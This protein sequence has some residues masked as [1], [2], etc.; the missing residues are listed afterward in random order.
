M[1]IDSAASQA[2]ANFAK[3][4]RNTSCDGTQI[5]IFSN[6]ATEEVLVVSRLVIKSDTN[7]FCCMP[8][9][10]DLCGDNGERM[11]S[12]PC[13]IPC[14]LGDT[15]GSMDCGSLVP[16]PEVEPVYRSL[17]G[18]PPVAAV[19][20]LDIP[21]P[22]G[23]VVANGD[24]SKHFLL[25]IGHL[26]LSE[27]GVSDA[28]AAGRFENAAVYRH[29]VGRACI[30]A[31]LLAMREN[32]VEP[33]LVFDMD[34][35]DVSGEAICC[36]MDGLFD[37]LVPG[38]HVVICVPPFDAEGRPQ[39]DCAFDVVLKYPPHTDEV[40][41]L[42]LVHNI[43]P[44]DPKGFQMQD[45]D[46]FI[47]SNVDLSL[48]ISGE[49]SPGVCSQVKLL[50][51]SAYLP[52][53]DKAA[54]EA[55]AAELDRL[56]DGMLYRSLT[57]ADS[58]LDYH[59]WGEAC[60]KFQELRRVGYWGKLG[61]YLAAHG[62]PDM[63]GCPLHC[64]NITG[65]LL[66]EHS[67]AAKL[68]I[69]RGTETADSVRARM[70]AAERKRTSAAADLPAAAAQPPPRPASLGTAA[71]LKAMLSVAHPR[72]RDLVSVYTAGVD[73]GLVENIFGIDCILFERMT[74]PQLEEVTKFTTQLLALMG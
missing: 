3:A 71:A 60:K 6:P 16:V 18:G 38:A 10:V 8:I 30:D 40:A 58:E 12:S 69:E 14:A 24:G 56:G 32:G 63:S 43:D 68:H 46:V 11:V 41:I 29:K 52:D 44:S 26:V 1:H 25:R 59:A 13:P 51:A 65:L 42:S 70:R 35:E 7:V 27:A 62:F 21:L 36:F 47:T 66:P 74:E 64:T 50:P 4:H 55:E 61:P 22:R 39:M 73:S 34:G 33:S 28:I 54:D 53:V 72:V 20:V 2:D 48:K 9:R 31:L 19:D 17:G 67:V 23:R 57:H 45:S 49:S 15:L 37:S 5:G